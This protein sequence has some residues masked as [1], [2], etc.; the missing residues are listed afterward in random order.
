[1]KVVLKSKEVVDELPFYI[2]KKV[3]YI[4]DTEHCFI[5]LS[6]LAH[7]FIDEYEISF[8]IDSQGIVNPKSIK[9]VN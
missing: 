3:I 7:T 1:M 8:I 4:Y 5:L 2:I 6:N 9:I